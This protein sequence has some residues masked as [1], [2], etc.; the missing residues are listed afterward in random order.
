MP[1][2]GPASAGAAQDR[3][4]SAPGPGDD[5]G[6]AA[7][8]RRQHFE[9]ASPRDA[10][11]STAGLSTDNEPREPP[12]SA[13]PTAARRTA[14]QPRSPATSRASSPY[15]AAC[16]RR[17]SASAATSPR[18]QVD[19]LAGV[20]KILLQRHRFRLSS[21]LRP[22]KM[23]TALRIH[24]DHHCRRSLEARA[25]TSNVPSRSVHASK[26]VT[27]PWIRQTKQVA[28]GPA[29]GA[30]S[31]LKAVNRSPFQGERGEGAAGPPL[32]SGGVHH[33]DV[34]SVQAPLTR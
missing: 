25:P 21:T 20:Q 26:R 31:D 22:E 24:P 13:P 14:L 16:S 33:D 29:A 28:L 4:A 27:Q 32:F 11:A 9:V 6:A 5:P 19:Q 17:N 30:K 15:Q 23:A 2:A 10:T 8:P 18:R 12:R 7:F 1:L 34:E 3:K